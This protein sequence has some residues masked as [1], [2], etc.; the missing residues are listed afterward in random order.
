MEYPKI[1]SLWK[2]EGWYFDEEKKKDRSFQEGRQSFR[3]GDYADDCYGNVKRWLVDEKIDGTN[4]RI[5]FQKITLDTPLGNLPI[6]P[7]I[8]FGGRTENAQIPCHLLD[9]LQTTFTQEKMSQTFPDANSVILFGEGY[10][11][12]IQ[13]CGGNYR[14]DVSFILFDVWCGGWWLKREDVKEIAKKLEINTVP[15]IGVMTEE[16]IIDFVKSKP[17]SRCSYTP[18]MLEGVVCR[19]EPLMLHRNG[20][21][22]MWKLKCKEFI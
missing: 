8:R 10:G 13:A 21:P 4:I 18:Q 22:I 12:K 5:F 6:I 7:Q 15:E 14:K 2:R 11:P 19:S 1:N 17:L 3:I 16:E 9:Y 20:K